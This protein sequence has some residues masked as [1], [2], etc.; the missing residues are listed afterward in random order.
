VG[1]SPPSQRSS[2][3]SAS[4]GSAGT[5]ASA[6][7]AVVRARRSPSRRSSIGLH[8]GRAIV[9]EIGFGGQAAFTAL[10][11]TVNLAHRLQEHARDHDAAA[12]V[13]SDVFVVAG[14]G[15]PPSGETQV[16]LRG[17]AAPIAVHLVGE[18]LG[19]NFF[20]EE[21]KQKTLNPAPAPPMAAL[22]GN[23]PP[24]QP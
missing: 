17:R 13:S 23:P 6:I 24:A 9:G 3:S 14:I 10:G 18:G 15:L 7:C 1:F 16:T 22:A 12:A 8:C 4:R 2:S 20:S 5:C 19:K 21:K 11:D